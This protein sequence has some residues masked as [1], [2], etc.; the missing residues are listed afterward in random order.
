MQNSFNMSSGG[1][2]SSSEQTESEPS[3]TR[4]RTTNSVDLFMS[5]SFKS[6]PLQDVTTAS[7]TIKYMLL[8]LHLGVCVFTVCLR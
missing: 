3:L 2:L 7:I 5:A 4:F 1:S 6:W 8:F